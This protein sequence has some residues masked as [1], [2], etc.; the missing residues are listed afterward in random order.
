MSERTEKVSNYL[1]ELVATFLAG[2]ANRNYLVSVTSCDISSDLKNSTVMLSVLPENKEGEVL[3]LMKEKKNALNKYLMDKL[4]IKYIPRITFL[5]DLGEKNRLR[6][7]E[8]TQ[9]TKL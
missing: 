6:V 8:L 5:I 7:E 4:H 9:Q 2:E 3:E 1:K